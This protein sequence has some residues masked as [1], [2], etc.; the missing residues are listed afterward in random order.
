MNATAS[1]LRSLL[2]KLCYSVMGIAA[3]LAAIFGGLVWS[4]MRHK[5]ALEQ[6]VERCVSL[7]PNEATHR[8]PFLV[9]AHGHGAQRFRN[10]EENH[11]GTKTPPLCPVSAF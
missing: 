9:L 5:A 3:V 11:Q 6:Q 2:S 4:K 7:P 1:P 8:Q 10:K